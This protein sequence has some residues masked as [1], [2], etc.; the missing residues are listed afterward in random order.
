MTGFDDLGFTCWVIEITI[1]IVSINNTGVVCVH[2]MW[3]CGRNKR[4][5][6]DKSA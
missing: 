1:P 6:Q 4:L 3:E 2:A 5:Q